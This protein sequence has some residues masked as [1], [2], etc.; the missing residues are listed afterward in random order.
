[1]KRN[2]TFLLTVIF[3]TPLQAAEP[4]LPPLQLEPGY[5]IYETA[6]DRIVFDQVYPEYGE[7][8]AGIVGLD[9]TL[10]TTQNG[11]AYPGVV[12]EC[13]ENSHR[14]DFRG[15]GPDTTWQSGIVVIKPAIETGYARVDTD[16]QARQ[17]L[18]TKMA[19]RYP[20]RDQGWPTEEQA[21]KPLLHIG[22]SF[23]PYLHYDIECWGP[24][25]WDYG[26]YNVCNDVPD[27]GS[28]LF[29]S[30]SGATVRIT[31]GLPLSLLLLLE[32]GGELIAYGSIQAGKSY[33]Y[34]AAFAIRFGEDARVV[35][36]GVE[37]GS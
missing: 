1:M 17:Q 4:A 16:P 2:I 23:G 35:F 12:A 32:H 18:L 21:G 30:R 24:G 7:C 15:Q 6:G 9:A 11:I 8:I 31:S 26:Y 29:D 36:E 27:A 3:T 28:Y 22:H 33:G 34:G 14:I 13:E 37:T 10:W 19:G 25:D 20:L 5:L